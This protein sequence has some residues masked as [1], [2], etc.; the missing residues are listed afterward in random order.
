VFWWTFFTPRIAACVPFVVG[1]EGQPS[2][3]KALNMVRR[4]DGRDQALENYATAF[5]GPPVFSHAAFALVGAVFFGFLLWR[6]RAADLA[7]AGLIAG[8]F[9]FT[10]SFFVLSL[11]CDYRYL[12]V[13]DLAVMVCGF[14]LAMDWRLS[15]TE[16]DQLS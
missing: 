10:L 14:Y 7:M 3:L 2:D 9:L 16:R 15:D 6:R 11:A 1:V 4:F 5:T 13:L 12:Y 8:A